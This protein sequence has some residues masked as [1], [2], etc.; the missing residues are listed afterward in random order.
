[1]REVLAKG[2]PEKDVADMFGV[3]TKTVANVIQG[4]TSVRT[5]HS[6]GRPPVLTQDELA[7][8]A[9]YLVLHPDACVKDVIGY[10]GARFNKDLKYE[11]VRRL[12]T[13]KHGF[14]LSDFRVLPLRRNSMDAKEKRKVYASEFILRQKEVEERGVFVDESGWTKET[15][16]FKG[17]TLKGIRP[18]LPWDSLHSA[19]LSVIAGVSVTHGVVHFEIESKTVASDRF[20]RYMDRLLDVA[21]SVFDIGKPIIILDNAP[22]HVSE[23]CKDW[24]FIH[25]NDCEFVRLP[26]YSPFLN[27]AEKVFSIWKKKYL[28]LQF[29]SKASGESTPESLIQESARHFT[30]AH[31]MAFFRHTLSFIV[32]SIQG[33]DISTHELFENS[34]EGDEHFVPF[35]GIESRWASAAENEGEE[36]GSQ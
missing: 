3:C 11:T 18:S 12:L 16:R 9:R 27:P 20:L 19:H 25:Q 35:E 13:Q 32:P 30:T 28:D 4:K 29:Q 5:V 10:L 24:F 34:H 33:L 36:E 1:M 17:W 22:I 8:G 14:K 6:G 31:C 23:L 2:R 15:R 21:K 26:P 7:A